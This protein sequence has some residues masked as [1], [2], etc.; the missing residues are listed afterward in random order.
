MDSPG[1]KQRV[2]KSAAVAVAFCAI[3]CGIFHLEDRLDQE[4]LGDPV[5]STKRQHFAEDAAPWLPLN[6]DD[7]INRFPDLGVGVGEDRL[8]MIA[9]DQIGETAE[10]FLCE[11]HAI[12]PKANS[13]HLQRERR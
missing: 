13:E 7:E 5:V 3:G 1:A 4:A 11:L 10:R 8:R 9:H 2:R 6:A 12:R